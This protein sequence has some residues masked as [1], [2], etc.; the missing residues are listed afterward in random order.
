MKNEENIKVQR[1]KSKELGCSN[2]RQFS[3]NRFHGKNNVLKESNTEFLCDP[4]SYRDSVCA[5]VIKENSTVQH[6]I[7]LGLATLTT[8]S[9]FHESAIMA[10]RF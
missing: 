1:A 8:N 9:V 7:Q 6:N 10:C 5:V 3:V 2:S 4:D